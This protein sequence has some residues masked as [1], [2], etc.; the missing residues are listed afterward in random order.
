VKELPYGLS[1]EVAL[2]LEQA[3]EATK[4]A[5]RAEGFG[6]LTE[7]DVRKTLK[8]QIG[9]EFQPYVILGACNPSLAFVALQ[10]DVETGLL[11]PCNVTVREEAADRSVISILDPNLMASVSPSTELKDVAGL[12]RQ[13]LQRVLEEL[14]RQPVN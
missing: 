10:D 6:V 3:I 12:A 9:A 14:S 13:K 1:T 11:I 2:P 4:E 8:D 7:I 5:L